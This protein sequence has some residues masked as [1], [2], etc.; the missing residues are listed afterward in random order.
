MG[1]GVPRAS[2]PRKAGERMGTGP[3]LCWASGVCAGSRGAPAAP[4]L[5]LGPRPQL[6]S[7]PYCSSKGWE[8]QSR[9]ARDHA[10]LH[11]PATPC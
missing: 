1:A 9:A 5:R 7:P 8:R 3:A 6:A 11:P 10:P 2:E 4:L